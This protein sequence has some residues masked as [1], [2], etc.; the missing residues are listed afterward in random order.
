M[1]KKSIVVMI[2]SIGAF[3]AI[4]ASL[5]VFLQNNPESSEQVKL[6]GIILFFAGIAI[7]LLASLI[8]AKK[9]K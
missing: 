5:F 8:L 3:L 7:V 9:K 4:F 6:I 1:K 2:G